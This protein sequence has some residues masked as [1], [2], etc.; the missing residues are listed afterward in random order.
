MRFLYLPILM[1]A[2]FSLGQLTPAGSPAS[3]TVVAPSSTAATAARR[4]P[5]TSVKPDSPV[6]I[7][8]GLCESR[9][10]RTAAAS[11]T[12]DTTACKTVI[13][14]AQ[15]DE[16]ANAVRPDMDAA[17]KRQLATLYPKL[18]VMQ[19]EFA[20]RGL[21]KDAN[22]RRALA[23]ATL[24]SQAE[25]MAKRLREETSNATPA[26]IEKYYKDNASTYETSE[27]QRIYVPKP[28][29][30]AH[31]KD[32]GKVLDEEATKKEAYEFQA[33]AAAG[34]S[35]FKLQD[36]AYKAAGIDGA[37]P[38]VYMGR[39]TG[40]DLPPSQRSVMAV[41]PGQVA[42][43]IED[44]SGYYIFK[45]MSKGVK[46]LALAQADIKAS[47]AQVK[48]TEAMQ[49]IEESVKTELNETYFPTSPP[50]APARKILGARPGGR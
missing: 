33:R 12:K 18:L 42:D 50:S 16:L 5:R 36:L 7:I 19:R 15:F 32:D 26:E 29:Q 34:E 45:V 8:D 25:E 46:P 38:P 23:F 37:R 35:F 14:R 21:E 11:S 3:V 39:V 20:K 13:T 24:R 28:R 1:L 9:P 22:V 30:P 41:K 31:G 40:S 47:L 6:I 27:L 49:K 48:F 10:A 44:P 43:V 17:T 4:S 2:P